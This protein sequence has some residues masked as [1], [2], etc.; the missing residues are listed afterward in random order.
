[1]KQR[2]VTWGLAL[3]LVLAQGAW[4][5]AAA[6]PQRTVKGRTPHPDD[7]PV[8]LFHACRRP[9]ESTREP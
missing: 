7:Q 9:H 3:A 2:M 5:E 4:L 8:G 1:M 6:A